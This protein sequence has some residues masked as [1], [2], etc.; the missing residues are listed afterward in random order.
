MKHL[1]PSLSALLRQCAEASPAEDCWS[2]LVERLTPWLYG[3]VGGALNLRRVS[4]RSDLVEE[5]VQEFWCR[6]LAADR[7]AL[8]GLRGGTDPEAS[9][10]LRRVVT[11]V[12]FDRL[13][14][15]GAEKRALERDGMSRSLDDAADEARFE[16]ADRRSCPE[17][18]LLAR[19]QGRALAR[20]CARLIGSQRRR[21][22]MEIARL[23]F[24]EGH[25]S[26]EIVERVGPPWSEA[27]IDSFL[28]RLRRRLA[29]L[30]VRVALRAGARAA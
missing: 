7:R 15:D 16:L 30:G 12:V 26:L 21:E 3:A 27:R 29:A 4:R 11:T 9:A 8:R 18:R 5:L 10:Y 19:E 24:V 17:A 2:D 22:R 14:R 23:A 6:L 13:R 28:F 25:S 20:S 1:E